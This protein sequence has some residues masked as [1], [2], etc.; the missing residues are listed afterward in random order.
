MHIVGSIIGIFH[1]AR[2]HERKI[3]S[4]VSIRRPAVI[5][6]IVDVNYKK[7]YISD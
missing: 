1:D 2:S 5:V 4:N 6:C 3:S 7:K